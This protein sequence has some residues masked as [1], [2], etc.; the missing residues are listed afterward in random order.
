MRVKEGVEKEKEAENLFR[1]IMTKNFK[2]LRRKFN[3]QVHDAQ[4]SPNRLNLKRSSLRYI[5]IKLSK[6]KY[7]ERTF[8]ATREK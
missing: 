8:N 1:E 7:K 6:V 3:L 5:K 2:I 4:V